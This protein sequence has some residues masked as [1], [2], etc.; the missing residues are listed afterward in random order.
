MRGSIFSGAFQKCPEQQLTCNVG[1]LVL[2]GTDVSHIDVEE[3]SEL[4]H[5]HAYPGDRNVGQATAA[6]HWEGEFKKKLCTSVGGQR[7]QMCVIG[8]LPSCCSL[9]LE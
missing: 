5:R 2:Q 1:E 3:G 6:V 9:I 4:G 8:K 7:T